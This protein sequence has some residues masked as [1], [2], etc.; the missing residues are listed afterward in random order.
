[1]INDM[2]V[3]VLTPVKNEDWILQKFLSIT[4]LFAD[5]I[6]LVDQGSTDRTKEIIASFPKAIYILNDNDDYDEEYRQRLLIDEARRIVPGKRLLLAID[7]DEIIT[8]NS[9]GDHEWKTISELEPGTQIYFKKP[10]VLSGL[11]QYYDYTDYFLLGFLDDGRD[12]VGT[13]FH[14]PRV[15]NSERKYK[16][17]RISFMHLALARALEYNARQRLYM[18]LE[19]VNNSDS[20]RLRYRKYSRKL[21]SMLRAD[22][23]RE[24]P[25]EWLDYPDPS[26]NPLSFN[27]SEENN[28]NVQ[29]LSKF[30][31]YGAKR[32]WMEDIWYVDYE[33]LNT[34][35]GNI[36]KS[37]IA[38]PP[39]YISAARISFIECYK[40][41]LSVQKIFKN[42]RNK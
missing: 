9:I 21:Q 16:S 15:P 35:L 23:I 38:T 7:A 37:K 3:V 40:V 39:L 17:D 27:S 8:A 30:A 11:K 25:A 13:R 33:M 36:C 12:H 29:I 28:F 22:I 19:N 34:L 42:F 6:I 24:V 32:F 14:S 4:S 10:D 1:M 41:V 18:V 5:H 26:I 20:L 2:S 31:E